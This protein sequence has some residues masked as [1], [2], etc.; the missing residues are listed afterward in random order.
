[1]NRRQ[2]QHNP[3][4]QLDNREE[5]Q[6]QQQ[7]SQAAISEALAQQEREQLI[8][9]LREPGIRGSSEADIAEEFGTELAG[10]YALANEDEEDTR[11]HH[12]LSANKRERHV[13]NRNPGRL[14][15]GAIRELAVGTHR[16]K[17]TTAEQPLTSHERRRVREVYD[18]KR[19]L[20]SLG[21]DGEGLSS[22]SEITAETRH[23]RDTEP[24][25]ETESGGVLNR[26]FG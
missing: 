10:L 14:C 9:I 7:A 17:T 19:A 13:A 6:A 15:R 3:K 8:E 2:P 16:D 1:M 18:L 25:E 21:K 20:H 11:R 5:A 4:E 26:V 12:F 23:V 22:V 24:T